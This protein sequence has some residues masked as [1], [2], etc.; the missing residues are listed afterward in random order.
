[1]KTVTFF[2]NFM[3]HDDG[4][5]A[6]EAAFMLPLYVL[7]TIGIVD[8][9]AGMFQS[10]QINAAA[11][12]GAASIVI[13]P[14]MSGV[15]A[16]MTSASGGYALDATLTKWTLSGGIATVT[17]TCDTVPSSAPCAPIVKWLGTILTSGFPA[18]LAST[19]TLRIE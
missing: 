13:S 18:H 10:M 7:L 1:M 9:G 15:S 5:A 16:A 17:A 2:R 12:A 3:R 11:Q 19:I 6:I 4:S 8:L 14:T